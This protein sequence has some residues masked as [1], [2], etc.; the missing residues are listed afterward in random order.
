VTGP[1]G[2]RR[3][4]LSV[5]RDE[6]KRIHGTI[7]GLLPQE[8][9]PLPDNRAIVVPYDHLLTLEQQHVNDFIPPGTEKRY[10]VAELLDG[11]E[12]QWLREFGESHLYPPLFVVAPQTSFDRAWEVFCCDVLN[13]HDGKKKIRRRKAP[14]GGI[15]LYC[16]SEKVAYQ[17]KSVVESTGKFSVSKAVKSLKDALETRK[18]LPWDRYVICSNVDL[19]GPQEQQLQAVFPDIEFLT[20][21][22]W[23]PR[24]REQSRYLGGRFQR[25]E[26]MDRRGL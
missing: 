12:D 4:F 14:E 9:V 23:I 25:L 5:I 20:P 10:G 21:S 6:F 1:E 11:I 13:R 15:D 3:G 24:C 2:G 18:K 8:M 19:T 26:R 16:A 17:C 22:F 7:P